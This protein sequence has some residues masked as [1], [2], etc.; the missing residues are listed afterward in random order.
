MLEEIMLQSGFLDG[1]PVQTVYFG[2]GTPSLLSTGDLG[3]ILEWVDSH[4]HVEEDAE[5]TVECNPDDVSREF[6]RDM[7]GMGFNRISLGVQSFHD[8]ELK[9]LGRRHNASQNSDALR[10]AVDLGFDNISIDLIYGLPGFT[11]DSWK[12][13]LE[14]AFKFPIKHMS[15]YHLTI[16]KGTVFGEMS[17][18]GELKELSEECSIEQFKVLLEYTS[19]YGFEDYELSNYALPDYRS[20]HNTAYWNQTPYLGIGPSAHSYDGKSRY[21]NVSDIKLYIELVDAGIIPFTKEQL[22]EKDRFNEYVITRLRTIWGIEP[23]VIEKQF[24][25]AYHRHLLEKARPCI[26]D[27][28]LI[29]RGNIIILS[30]KGKF[31]SD[32]IFRELIIT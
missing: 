19:K 21:W 12:S 11:T 7:K 9:F 26:S 5:I 31:I 29:R 17:E 15:A 1:K 14:T 23:E 28:S 4:F 16:E 3:I 8:Y 20:R 32:H 30:D 18:R 2:G 6:F 25:K 22:S 27:G 13:T 24:G 10:Y